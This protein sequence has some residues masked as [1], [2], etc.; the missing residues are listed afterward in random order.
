LFAGTL[1]LLATGHISGINNN[2]FNYM[3]LGRLYDLPQFGGDQAVGSMRHYASGFWM[4]FVGAGRWISPDAFFLTWAWIARVALCAALLMWAALIGIR[5]PL[6]RAAFLAIVLLSRYMQGFAYAGEG[7][8]LTNYFSHSDL[9]NASMLVALYFA[10]R[11]R[12][13]FACL[14]NGV[15]FFINAFMSIWI[16]VPFAFLLMRA[17]RAGEVTALGAARRMAL[18]LAGFA[19]FTI[20]VVWATFANPE[21]GAQA[22]FAYRP[23]LLEYF[24]GHFLVAGI[25]GSNIRH[26]AELLVAG[27]AAGWMIRRRSPAPLIALAGYACVWVLG[28]M[29]P[30]VVDEP[31]VY[32]LHLLRSSVGIHIFAMIAIAGFA[33]DLIKRRTA[34]GTLAASAI[35]A[36][37]IL[38]AH[39]PLPLMI[40][41]LIATT[42]DRWSEWRPLNVAAII[43]LI[44]TGAK[45]AILLSHRW[46][47]NRQI[48]ERVADWRELAEWVKANTA[49]DATF[50]MP[51]APIH[52][53]R[54]A[55]SAADPD[56]QQA[57]VGDEGFEY[58]AQRRVWIDYKRGGAVMWSPTYYPMWKSRVSAVLALP[59]VPARVAFAWANRIG[60]VAD[61]CV[62]GIVAV[63]RTPTVC[64]YKAVA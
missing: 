36:A 59:N 48:S 5:R 19:L 38:A 51:T 20:P 39:G 15:T 9:A 62:P 7:D 6:H 3:T 53:D 61:R 57:T 60:F 26:L 24:P 16:A 33:M 1:S 31:E 52:A 42:V 8:L 64:V 23:Y 29:L 2:L 43:F 49:P 32:I 11:G 12:F 50:L 28:A 17:V 30:A 37:C 55:L 22:A 63:A 54:F 21:A 18:G 47:A 34:R 14:A 10:A 4:P 56:E 44:G 35:F 40:V 58:Y 41:T 25:D 13:V 46:E 45:Q 27:L